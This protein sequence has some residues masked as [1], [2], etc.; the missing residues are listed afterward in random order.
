MLN[1]NYSP[2]QVLYRGRVIDSSNQKPIPGVNVM[3]NDAILCTTT[4]A[5]KYILQFFIGQTKQ[6]ISF[7]KEGYA[8][9]EHDTILQPLGE[10]MMA[11]DIVMQKIKK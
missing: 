7:Q 1:I 11:P 4:K 8:T 5:G 10:I 3:I 6:K 2:N 9:I